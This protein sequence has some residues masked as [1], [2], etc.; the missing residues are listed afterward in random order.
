VFSGP[1]RPWLAVHVF[2]YA[3]SKLSCYLLSFSQ[4]EQIKMQKNVCMYVCQK[5]AVVTARVRF[6]LS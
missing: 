2:F 6:S 1:F 4:F 5:C 3:L